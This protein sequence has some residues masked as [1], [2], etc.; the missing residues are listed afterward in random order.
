MDAPVALV[1]GG[2]RRLGRRI[3][4]ALAE[5]GFDLAINYNRSR[6][7]AMATLRAVK[8]TGREGFLVRADVR[9]R[10]QVRQMVQLILDRFGRIDLLVNNAAIFHPPTDLFK[11]SDRLWNDVLSTNLYGSFICAQEVSKHMTKRKSGKIINIASVGGLSA[12]SGHIPYC[13]SKAGLIMLTRTLARA[14]GP[15]I[16]V[17]AIAPGTIIIPK[18]ENIKSHHP[19][20]ERIPLKKYGQPSDIVEAVLY[21]ARSASYVT[22]QVIAVDGGATVF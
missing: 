7:D 16:T 22:G 20:V 13:V 19:S 2:G 18:E 11:I 9:K 5:N 8:G 4:I 15:D 12:W 6:I 14:L 21:L 10:R 1:T 17:N 3:V